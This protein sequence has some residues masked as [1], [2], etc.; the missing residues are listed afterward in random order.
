MALVSVPNPQ[1]SQ[2]PREPALRLCYSFFLPSFPP[3]RYCS[4]PSCLRAQQVGKAASS[5]G[6]ESCPPRCSCC[7]PEAPGAPEQGWESGKNQ[8]EGKH[9]GRPEAYPNKQGHGG[10]QLWQSTAYLVW[11]C[12]TSHGS[13]QEGPSPEGLASNISGQG[14]RS[15]QEPESCQENVCILSHTTSLI[16]AFGSSEPA[17]NFEELPKKT[18][19]KPPVGWAARDQ[20]TT[21]P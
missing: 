9:D 14:N 8:S 2:D 21:L 20:G 4:Q 12:W 19:F 13:L 1:S 16:Q 10:S 18:S 7:N 3:P 5:C 6:Q 17:L 15:L 11:S